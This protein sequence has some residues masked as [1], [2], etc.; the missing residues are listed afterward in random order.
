M[1]FRSCTVP[2]PLDNRRNFSARTLT[3]W[4]RVVRFAGCTSNTN[5][6]QLGNDKTLRIKSTPPST[7]E[8]YFDPPPS[9]GE[10]L[11]FSSLSHIVEVSQLVT[12]ES[13]VAAPVL[14]YLT[15]FEEYP[16][17]ELP[18]KT[19]ALRISSCSTPPSTTPKRRGHTPK[20]KQLED[21]CFHVPG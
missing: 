12:P 8:E 18:S 14:L 11:K 2:I 21:T 10:S 20:R 16:P 5:P 3:A 15:S 7:D 17:L 13:P 1:P 9:P 6:C 4:L 19:T